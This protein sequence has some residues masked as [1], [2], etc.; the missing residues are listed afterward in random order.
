MN[1]TI[2]EMTA[3]DHPAAYALWKACEG[4]GLSESDERPAIESFLERNPG[5]SFV[6]FHDDELVG[7]I[8]GG[9]DGRRGFIYHLAVRANYRKQGIGGRLVDLSLAALRSAGIIKCHLFVFR[10]NTKAADFWAGSGWMERS[11]L[12]LFSRNPPLPDR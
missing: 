10:S 7:T 1:P 9:H 6:A 4:V 12:F 5:L 2:R 8:L 3:A 11:D